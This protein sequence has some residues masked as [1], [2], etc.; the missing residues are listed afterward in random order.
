MEEKWEDVLEQYDLKVR[1]ILWARGAKLLE[2][3]QGL[4]QLRQ[5]TG[6][7][8]QLA[9]ENAL[10]SG[11]ENNGYHL[12]DS[13]LNTR[14]G[15][16]YALAAKKY[17]KIGKVRQAEEDKA[18]EAQPPGQ[19]GIVSAEPEW[20]QLPFPEGKD[21]YVIRRWFAGEEGNFRNAEFLKRAAA[22]LGNLHNAMENLAIPEELI[23][24]HPSMSLTADW[25]KHNRELKRIRRYILNKKQKN[26]FEILFLSM[27]EEYME[28][29][30]S[31]YCLFEQENCRELFAEAAKRHLFCHGN[32][33]YHNLLDTQ[34]GIAAVCFEEAGVGT[35]VFDL[36]QMMRKLLEKNRWDKEL[37]VDVLKE[38]E[39]QRTLTNEE[40]KLLYILLLY[41]EKFW[42]VSNHYYNSR[43]SWIN[44]IDIA[45]LEELARQ[46][47]KR[48]ETLQFFRSYRG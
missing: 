25:Q 38:Y 39:K 34:E 42:K 29:A 45:K 2:T 21:V 10:T 18:Q 20:W 3:D 14:E 33:N 43:K 46:Q 4:F 11:L 31:A 35:P 1:R 17:G 48:K 40:H 23:V 15:M 44:R 28:A 13:I 12:L 32:Y 16:P 22:A 24:F 47:K 8:R 37:A 6:K 36:Y 26:E 19:D 5:F 30:G 7:P 41:P 9:L 27:E